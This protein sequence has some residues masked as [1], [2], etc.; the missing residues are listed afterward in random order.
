MDRCVLHRVY[1]LVFPNGKSYVGQTR[2]L[3]RERFEEHVKYS[4]NDALVRR[5]IDKYGA[6]TVRLQTLAVVCEDDVDTAERIFIA[7]YETVAPL[8]YNLAAG[9]R[10]IMTP[11]EPIE[12]TKLRCA[13]WSAKR[14][15]DYESWKLNVASGLS[16]ECALAVYKYAQLSP[17]RD[18]NGPIF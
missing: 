8:G 5:A 13:F 6:D 1:R 11:P 2:R 16:D 18:P 9:G 14:A 4:K 7:A 3:P 10:G 12:Y 17:T 15:K